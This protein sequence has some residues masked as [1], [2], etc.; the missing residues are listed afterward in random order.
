MALILPSLV[1]AAA[2]PKYTTYQ[3]RII[4]PNNMPLEDS[5]V[6]FRFTLTNPA[7]NCALYVE[8]FSNVDMTGSAGNVAFTLGTG[9]QSYISAGNTDMMDIF[10]NNPTAPY[11]CQ[12]G[13]GPYTPANN[14]SRKIVMAFQ[15]S[16]LGWQVLPAMAINSVPYAN[17]ANKATS[18]VSATFAV[19]ASVATTAQNLNGYTQ[20]DFATSNGLGGGCSSGEVLTF[21]GAAFVCVSV[22]SV[23]GTVSN[24]TA[25][26]P[27][28]KTG[29]ASSPILSI[30]QSSLTVDG[31]LSSTD[32]VTFNNKLNATS[33]AITTALGAQALTVSSTINLS[34]DV[35]G[36]TTS[37]VVSFVN[38]KTASQVS[39]SVDDT[40][41]ATSVATASTIAKRDSSGNIIFNNIGSNITSM[42]RLNLYN[43]ANAISFLSPVLA[44]SYTL[45]FPVSAGATDQVLTTDGAG[46]LSWTS[47]SAG[48][49]TS[50]SGTANEVSV[51]GT[52][53]N[54]VVGLAN[55][56][57]VS[58]TY[59]KVTVDSKGRV[60][61]A[62]TLT[63][64]DIPNLDTNK[65]TSGTFSVARGGTG[66]STLTVSGVLIGNGTSA[67]N[68]V[69][70]GSSG[71][72]LTINGTGSPI[73]LTPAG[74]GG[75]SA[76]S[77]F[78][79]ATAT[80]TIDSTDFAQVWNWS[81]LSTQSALTI[82]A[83]ALTT[84]S[85]LSLTTPN[86]TVSSINGLL[87]VANTSAGMGGIVAR[88]QSN[89]TAGS[90]LTVLAS[91]NVGIGTSTPVSRL[92][93][94][95]TLTIDGASTNGRL[96][97]R[98]GFDFYSTTSGGG[99]IAKFKQA[100]GNATPN[101]MTFT[102]I[103]PG[104]NPILSVDG[105]DPNISMNI[106]PKGTGNVNFVNGNVGIG[107]ANPTFPLEVVGAIKSSSSVMVGADATACGASRNGSIRLN[108][109][110]LEYCNNTA[111]TPLATGGSLTGSTT[112]A[113]TYNV[114]L[115]VNAGATFDGTALSN[116]SVGYDA[117]KNTT[118]G[119]N[120]VAVGYQAGTSITT[121]LF[122]VAIGASAL[123]TVNTGWSNIAVGAYAMELATFPSGENIAI[124]QSALRSST[125]SESIA[126]GSNAAYGKT[127]GDR[128]IAIGFQSYMNTT[129][130]GGYSNIGIGDSTMRLGNVSGYHN[131]GIGAE[132]LI[133]LVSGNFN[134][135]LGMATLR[136]NTTGAYNTANGV[137]ALYSNRAK[138][139]STAIGFN[140]MANADDTT[141]AAI[142]YNT[143]LGA[144]S[145]QGSFTAADNTGLRNTAL[146]HSSL[147]GMAS[148]SG[149]IGVGYNSGSAI[150]TGSNNVVIGSN[151]GSTFATGSGNISINDG[152][153][154]ERI[155]VL[156]SG[157][158]GIGNTSP[159]KLLHV[160]SASVGTGLAVANFQNVDGTCTITPAA[161][162]SG[163]A[164]S[165]DE[166]LKENF[167]DVQGFYALDH[168][169]KLQAVTYNFKTASTETRRTGY[170]AQEIQK[171]APEFVRQNDDGYFQV[172]YDG[173]IPWITEAIKTLYN[174]LMGVK[175]DQAIQARQI[176]SK[177]D[178][179]TVDAKIKKLEAENAELKAR[180]EKIE[181]ALNSK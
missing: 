25:N 173:L 157:N 67:V 152:A 5:N 23:S 6:M 57:V 86:A 147:L 155:R 172:Y 111:W 91:G 55:N 43:G 126:I 17:Y 141:T 131:V 29:S 10:S 93:V 76:L 58:G 3:A 38:G 125:G 34:G 37:T 137:N 89:S 92:H 163:I 42:N 180:L 45:T 65:I 71:T 28:V 107:Q 14:D 115:G 50:V 26:T 41:A 171:V 63:A 150:T 140:A 62:T 35:T 22:A 84:G 87:Y 9:T 88:I 176:A 79:S 69:T 116:V 70:A 105:S 158:V 134:V 104:F 19:S 54:P 127:T 164:C 94:S 154:N 99:V 148:G 100:S 61:S 31:Y 98:N 143:A 53:S 27:L 162:G 52:A 7:A 30:T 1:F 112:G 109:T 44:S 142:T 49:V 168:I 119:D 2:A 181:K 160:G 46:I 117:M 121:G 161:A 90:G 136:S 159:S 74:G 165:S 64:S 103:N 15:I 153:G 95:G 4:K 166:R 82:S 83:S 175:A 68:T 167:Q 110:G 47:P 146:G 149:N 128:I 11:S 145:L 138:H 144:Y 66:L 179:A 106:S 75:S 151:T 56:G 124:G 174:D 16:G 130:G 81:T 135:G 133:S 139:E 13:G 120:N 77:S 59:T 113:T 108:G 48:S 40:I 24:I 129:N 122:N 18:A 33:S 97:G 39:T 114:T 169:L 156:A 20:S 101:Y 178:S 72:V 21:N 102:N 170:K 36:N 60:S 123:K 177:A 132:A 51:T 78:T 73:W 32:F 118:Q 96:D 12:G 85:L 80:N 8:T